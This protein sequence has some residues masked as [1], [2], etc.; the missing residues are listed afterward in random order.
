[1]CM[2]AAVAMAQTRCKGRHA[3]CC[4]P[5]LRSRAATA[6]APWSLPLLAARSAPLRLSGPGG[7]APLQRGGMQ[8]PPPL[9]WCSIRPRSECHCL[10]PHTQFRPG[11][12]V[13]FYI[14][15][16]ARGTAAEFTVVPEAAACLVPS[17][18]DL[19]E[20]AAVPLV[21]CTAWQVSLAAAGC[22]CAV[23]LPRIMSRSHARA[24]RSNRCHCCRAGPR[25]VHA[26]GGQAR[27]HPGRLRCLGSHSCNGSTQLF[28]C[29]NH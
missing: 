24:C 26:A 14:S 9:C 12:A 17:G 10:P 27:A 11:D 4:A 15:P 19:V 20:A 16:L 22:H 7:S 25:E 1:M 18:T 13:F 2:A 6:R 3:K 5:E 21:A 28:M 23:P 29:A 8:H